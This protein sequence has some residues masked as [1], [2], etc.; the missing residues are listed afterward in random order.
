[1]EKAMNL[2]V[3]HLRAILKIEHLRKEIL[4]DEITEE[5]CQKY[6][7][8]TDK[9]KDVIS[10]QVEYVMNN[11]FANHL[12]TY[13]NPVDQYIDPFKIYG[14]KGIYLV[15]DVESEFL[16]YFTNKKE[17]FSYANQAYENWLDNNK[18]ED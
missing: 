15:L 2:N 14:E 18:F 8:L 7:S 6:E 13:S 11:G 12:M 1:M 10:S 17:A 3:K 9:E 5:N 16:T 4:G